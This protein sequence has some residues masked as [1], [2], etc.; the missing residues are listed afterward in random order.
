MRTEIEST[1]TI[2]SLSISRRFPPAKKEPQKALSWG[3]KK[4]ERK[5]EKTFCGGRRRVSRFHFTHSFL[6]FLSLSPALA[7]ERGKCDSTAQSSVNLA[8]CLPRAAWKA[9]AEPPLPKAT[10]VLAR[11][12]FLEGMTLIRCRRRRSLLL[13]ASPHSSIFLTRQFS[14]LSPLSRTALHSQLCA[15]DTFP[16]RRGRRRVSGVWDKEGGQ[17]ERRVFSFS[18]HIH[19]HCRWRRTGFIETGGEQ[20]AAPFFC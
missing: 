14:P 16:P 5:R 15:A 19:L 9:E 2:G 10:C 6:L 20:T 12:F 7:P 4:R 8:C 3:S 17:K 18:L 13:L 1:S 11:F